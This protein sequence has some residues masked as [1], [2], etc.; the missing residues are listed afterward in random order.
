MYYAC[1]YMYSDSSYMYRGSSSMYY[2][3]TYTYCDSSS[4]YNGCTYTYRGNTYMY[5]AFNQYQKQRTFLFML[6]D[7]SFLTN[8]QILVCHLNLFTNRI[9]PSLSKRFIIQT[10]KPNY[11]CR[12]T[13]KESRI[14]TIHFFSSKS[15]FYYFNT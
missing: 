8:H 2:D 11:F 7:D 4:T 10:F 12:S 14:C 15:F 9:I 6:I 13:T 5:K 3:F 1:I